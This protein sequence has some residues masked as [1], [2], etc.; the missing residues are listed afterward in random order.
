MGKD[1]SNKVTIVTSKLDDLEKNFERSE[2][3]NQRKFSELK[4]DIANVEQLVTSKVVES[5][6]P[7]I[8]A[9]KTDITSEMRSEMINLL[10]DE[11]EN[12]YKIK[13]KDDDEEEVSS[14]EEVEAPKGEPVKKKK[15]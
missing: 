2:G 12:T 3:E 1:N 6:K 5:M 8:S 7:Q 15:N 11:M 9:L 13:K 14:E 10:R 4:T